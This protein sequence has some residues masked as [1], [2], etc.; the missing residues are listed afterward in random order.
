[1]YLTIDEY[2]EIKSFYGEVQ[3]IIMAKDHVRVMK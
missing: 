1:M 2:Q 3:E